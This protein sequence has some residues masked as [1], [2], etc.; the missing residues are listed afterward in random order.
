[1]DQ[2]EQIN[3]IAGMAD[4]TK[5]GGSRI[6]KGII[7]MI[8]KEVKDSGRLRIAGLGTFKK[9]HRAGGLRTNPQ[10][11]GEK[12]TVGPHDTVTFRPDPEFKRLVNI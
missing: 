1:M 4:T 3:Y 7:Q 10:K 12:V 5:A 2:A 9:A 6:L 8:L 11:P